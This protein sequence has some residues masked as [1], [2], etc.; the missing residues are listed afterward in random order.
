M[1]LAIVIG[2]LVGG[3]INL[4]VYRI[5]REEEQIIDWV[6]VYGLWGL[7]PRARFVRNYTIIAVNLG[8]C[9]IPAALAAWQVARLFPEG[10]R[11][12]TALVVACGANVAACYLVARPVNNVGIVIP[13]FL[14]PAV[15]IGATC[16]WC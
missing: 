4:P 3:L 14:S 7:F 1:A 2:M 15:A 13:G 12:L 5:D 8:G 16:A 11:P 10:G 6:S 9:V